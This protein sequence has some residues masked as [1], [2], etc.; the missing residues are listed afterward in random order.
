MA[1]AEY[2]LIELEIPLE[3][4]G[5]YTDRANAAL[6]ALESTLRVVV[7]QTRKDRPW[8]PALFEE[9]YGDTTGIRYRE[10]L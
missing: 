4:D 3:P 6:D 9:Y 2:M 8:N 10:K 1:D 7:I 5:D